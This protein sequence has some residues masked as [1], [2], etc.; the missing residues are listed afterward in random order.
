MRCASATRRE[1]PPWGLVAKRTFD[2][3]VSATALVGNFAGARVA[4]VYGRH[5]PKPDSTV[6]RRDAVDEVHGD[7]RLVKDPARGL[8]MG[9]P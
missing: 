2:I 8:E 9:C 5:V 1:L 4:A 7:K 6:D 3:L